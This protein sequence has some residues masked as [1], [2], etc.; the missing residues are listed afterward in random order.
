MSCKSTATENGASLRVYDPRPS[1]NH[2]RHTND[3]RRHPCVPAVTAPSSNH[4]RRNP[5]R[6]TG[7]SISQHITKTTAIL[8]LA[9]AGVL[10]SESDAVRDTGSPN[11]ASNEYFLRLAGR[12]FVSAAFEDA[13]GCE[14]EVAEGAAGFVLVLVLVVSDV[15]DADVQGCAR[16]ISGRVGDSGGTGM[17]D[18]LVG[19]RIGDVDPDVSRQPVIS[20]HDPSDDESCVDV[21]A[22]SGPSTVCF[23]LTSD[24]DGRL[25]MLIVRPRSGELSFSFSLSLFC[26]F[27]TSALASP[28]RRVT[29]LAGR[30]TRSPTTRTWLSSAVFE[31]VFVPLDD[32]L[33]VTTLAEVESSDDFDGSQADREDASIG[34]ADEEGPGP[35]MNVGEV[36]EA[37]PF[38][39]PRFGVENLSSQPSGSDETLITTAR[40]AEL[41]D[42]G[43]GIEV[44]AGGEGKRYGAEMETSWFWS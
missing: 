43:P 17:P 8:T 38:I 1:S 18:I 44:E 21:D 9:S 37:S 20:G 6:H 30:R 42:E 15:I 36:G 13:E 31:L 24:S 26:S 27:S 22:G 3:R 40:V 5:N 19:L 10:D 35:V 7:L 16:S 32:E 2:A 29:F 28:F 23:D 33:G 39:C 4:R 25:F 14:G 41:G 11:A 34:E 12:P